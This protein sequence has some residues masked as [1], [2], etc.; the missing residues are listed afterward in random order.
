MN[1]HADSENRN[2][3][4]NAADIPGEDPLLLDDFSRADARSQLGTQWEGFTDR[5]MGGR[6][7]MQV[8]VADSDR[9]PALHM[10]GEVSLENNGGFIQARLALSESGSFNA[11]EYRG[12][13]VE[14]RGAG[15]HYYLHIRTNRTR[16]PWAHYAAEMPVREEWAWVQLPFDDFEPQLM[17]GGG[18][19]D[20]RR[21]R[22]IAVVAA[23]AEF[24]ADLWLR[25]VALYR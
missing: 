4:R 6:S 2:P 7:D 25:R 23:K 14:V 16:F 22:S 19:P 20:R 12:V 11:E 3:L 5:V 17:L 18:S 24:T 10:T 1:A 21:L 13:A 8:A 9:G 15:D